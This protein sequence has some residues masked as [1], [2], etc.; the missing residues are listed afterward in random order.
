[1]ETFF[2]S[3]ISAALRRCPSLLLNQK[4]RQF[5]AG[6]SLSLAE[7]DA[8]VDRPLDE[9]DND[10]Y[11]AGPWLGTS[12]SLPTSPDIV[13]TGI[14]QG[15][16]I[17]EKRCWRDRGPSVEAAHGVRLAESVSK[18]LGADLHVWVVDGEYALTAATSPGLDARLE[19][20]VGDAICHWLSTRF[21]SARV[22]RTS[23]VETRRLI[24]GE[25]AT[26]RLAVAFPDRV[27]LP[28]GEHNASF[29]SQLTFLATIAL[30]MLET[31]DKRVLGIFDCHQWRAV[32][33]AQHLRPATFSASYYW[34]VPQLNW[35][36]GDLDREPRKM[37]ERM[38]RLPR[39]MFSASA[40][41]SKL[42]VNDTEESIEARISNVE[43]KHPRHVAA[44]EEIAWYA[45]G[46][47]VFASDL[48]VIGRLARLARSF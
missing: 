18:A 16:N 4:E 46:D 32:Q 3:V 33:M 42:F 2:P 5:L 23:D 41:A 1:M 36:W 28:Y 26:S 45:T 9:P 19:A 24:Y 13:M 15:R 10:V 31:A 7:R 39:R 8:L 11:G 22:L 6:Q 29:W 38:Q 40:I 37:A 48:D 14:C 43:R 47:S 34:P 12:G 27:R 44:I 25:L 30:I 35:S 21:P 20:E 17:Q